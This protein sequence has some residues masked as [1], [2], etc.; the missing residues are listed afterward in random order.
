[1]KTT[2]HSIDW[3]NTKVLDRESNW[4]KRGVKEAINIRRHQPTLNKDKG[5]HHLPAAY[6][7]LVLSDLHPRS[8]E[9][10]NPTT[11]ETPASQSLGIEGY[12]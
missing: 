12:M 2:D 5:H 8:S 10:V 7:Q 3:D 1:M 6:D 11:Q 9:R 4:T